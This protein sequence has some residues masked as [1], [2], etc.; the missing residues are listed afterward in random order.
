MAELKERLRLVRRNRVFLNPRIKVQYQDTDS[1]YIEMIDLYSVPVKKEYEEYDR[2]VRTEASGRYN[3]LLC[4]FLEISMGRFPLKFAFEGAFYR[5]WHVT[6]KNYLGYKISAHTC[7]LVDGKIIPLDAKGKETTIEKGIVPVV[8]L[9][10]YDGHQ[11]VAQYLKKKN[12]KVTG[13]S[14]VKR[15]IIPIS[16]RLY[17]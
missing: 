4:D 17:L 11:N 5:A 2:Y 3:D 13:L 15:N 7:K 10:D 8:K 1:N 14:V 9:D 12:I 6:K 16:K